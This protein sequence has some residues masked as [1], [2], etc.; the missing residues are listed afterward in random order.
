MNL[1]LIS[2]VNLLPINLDSSLLLLAPT[3]KSILFWF[4]KNNLPPPLKKNRSH[5]R[6]WGPGPFMINTMIHE[7]CVILYR[8]DQMHPRPVQNTLY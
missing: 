5:E 3:F 6:H 8:T 7:V 2:K 1:Q 4:Q